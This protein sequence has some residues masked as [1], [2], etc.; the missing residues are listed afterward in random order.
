MCSPSVWGLRAYGITRSMAVSSVS[1]MES[2]ASLW[3]GRA[4]V[5]RAFRLARVERHAIVP[6]IEG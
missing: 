3:V 6:P 4:G 1:I 5:G 2:F